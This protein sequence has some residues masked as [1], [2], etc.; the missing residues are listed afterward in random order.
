MPIARRVGKE[1]VLG[2][3]RGILRSREAAAVACYTTAHIPATKHKETLPFVMT[4]VDLEGITLNEI[5]Q[6]H[7]DK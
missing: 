2:T 5:S 3:H 1:G 7:T 6:T 4:W